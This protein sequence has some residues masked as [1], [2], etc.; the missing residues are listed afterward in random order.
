MKI[1]LSSSERVSPHPPA[2]WTAV[3]K[4]CEQQRWATLHERRDVRPQ[5]TE[6]SVTVSQSMA[7]RQLPRGFCRGLFVLWSVATVN[8]SDDRLLW[9]GK[10]MFNTVTDTCD[11][12]WF[13][14]RATLS[15]PAGRP[16][17]AFLHSLQRSL[18]SED[19]IPW[20][21]VQTSH[22]TRHGLQQSWRVWR[23]CK[24]SLYCA[25]HIRDDSKCFYI[26]TLKRVWKQLN[27]IKRG[28]KQIKCN[29]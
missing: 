27:K 18:R 19:I 5:K 10:L 7:L 29:I 23:I 9:A 8:Q 21:Q 16:A 1:S 2:L 3:Q 11:C 17:A 20:W 14:C 6:A 22:L 26:K 25:F 28:I 13:C 24:A 12:Y 4:V 15:K